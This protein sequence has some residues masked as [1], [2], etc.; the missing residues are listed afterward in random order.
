MKGITWSPWFLVLITVALILSVVSIVSPGPIGPQGLPGSPGP[1]GAQGAAGVPGA[2]G[3]DGAMGPQGMPGQT[4]SQGIVGPRGLTGQSGT[5]VIGFTWRG[6]WRSSANYVVND[7]VGR[8]GNSYICILDNS[9]RRPPSSK[10]WDLMFSK[11]SGSDTHSDTLTLQVGRSSDDCFRRLTGEGYWSLTH[12]DQRAGAINEG[13]A[14]SGGGMRFT[15]VTIPEDA[16]IY[17]AHLTL[18]CREEF[19]GTN[20]NTWISAEDVGDAPTFADS[21]SVF[22]ERRNNS[23]AEWVRWDISTVWIAERNYDSP[24][25]S[26]IIQEVVNDSDWESG[27]DIVLFWDDFEGRSDTFNDVRIVYSYDGSHTYAPKLYIK[28]LTY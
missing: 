19:D 23:T 16:I 14:Q 21:A 27:N 13:D 5:N 18:R 11:V 4:G 12:H 26:A 22:D 6:A 3:V 15:D 8:S 25:I 2:P 17:E 9:K 28:Y 24:D 20:C 10:Y 7:V 1:A